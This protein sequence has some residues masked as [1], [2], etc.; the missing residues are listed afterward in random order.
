MKTQFDNKVRVVSLENLKAICERYSGT[1]NGYHV[2]KVTTNRVYISTN[3]SASETESFGHTVTAVFPAWPSGFDGKENPSVALEIMRVIGETDD[4]YDASQEF[5]ALLDC[6]PLYRSL[7][8]DKE[9]WQSEYEILSAKYGYS[10]ESRWYQGCI[11]FWHVNDAT[12]HMVQTFAP[13]DSDPSSGTDQQRGEYRDYR[14][15]QTAVVAHCKRIQEA[16]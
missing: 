7:K 11:Q 4:D 16:K 3:T 8:D 13:G 5:W 10:I 1:C 14:D 9:L 15:A 12:G 2:D 6:E